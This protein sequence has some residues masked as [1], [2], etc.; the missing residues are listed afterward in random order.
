M[1]LLGGFT[2][3]FMVAPAATSTDPD[4][5]DLSRRLLAPGEDALLGTDN[6]GRDALTR[7]LHGG[8]RTLI[9]GM[10]AVGLSTVAATIIGATAGYLGG[11]PDLVIGAVLD[12]LL[13]LPGLLVTLTLLGILGT[14]PWT[15]ILALVGGSWAGE[16][17]VLRGAVYAVRE[18]AYVEAARGCGAGRAR[19]LVRHVLPNVLTPIIVLAS[20]NLGE[21]LLV[22]SALSFL[23]LGV[24]PPRADWGVMLADSRTVFGQAPWLMLA[25]GLCIVA[26][27]LLANLSGDALR[28]LLDPR[29]AR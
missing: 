2:L 19:I 9:T 25:P 26:F 13:S 15:L 8:Q 28:G 18:S 10:L 6:L 20:L 1:L 16:A 23:G 7:L 21:V 17:R 22:V 27:S 29:E 24:Q 12:I 14:A 3:V 5:L 4:A 11:W